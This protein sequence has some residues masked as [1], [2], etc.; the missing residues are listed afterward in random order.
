MEDIFLIPSPYLIPASGQVQRAFLGGAAAMSEVFRAIVY[1][2][3]LATNPYWETKVGRVTLNSRCFIAS[4]FIR[5]YFD[6]RFDG[7]KMPRHWSSEV[8]DRI[9]IEAVLW[10]ETWKLIEQLY[11]RSV[12]APDIHP[13]VTFFKVVNECALLQPYLQILSPEEIENLTATAAVRGIQ[14]QNRRLQNLGTDCVQDLPF[15]QTTAPA[16]WQLLEQC[17]R[18][19]DISKDFRDQ[20]LTVIKARM[21]FASH[22]KGERPKIHSTH[23]RKT[24]QR[25]RRL[26]RK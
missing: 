2:P 3:D 5:R 25:G 15:A 23:P 1:P 14:S 9:R 12:F 18:L 10:G 17:R 8:K 13:S 4:E 20:Y 16:T 26:R 22:L 21:T 11:G 6:K 19:A 7:W 24:E